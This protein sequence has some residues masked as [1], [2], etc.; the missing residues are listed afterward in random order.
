MGKVSRYVLVALL[1]ALASLLPAQIRADDNAQRAKAASAAALAK[2]SLG[3]NGTGKAELCPCS[4]ADVCLCPESG[5]YACPADCVTSG[6]YRWVETTNSNQTALYK[7]KVQQGN[8]WHKESEYRRLVEHGDEYHFVTDT[9][10]VPAPAL[11]TATESQNRATT[12]IT[13]ARLP[14]LHQP[15]SQKVYVTPGV[16]RPAYQSYYGFSGGGSCGPSG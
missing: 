2:I 6:V 7:G 16:Y 9:C 5:N 4:Q 14:V 10:P 15:F 12:V 13:P 3:G 1:L 8:W 11:A